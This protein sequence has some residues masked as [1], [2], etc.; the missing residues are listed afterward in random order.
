MKSRGVKTDPID[1]AFGIL[2][3]KEDEERVIGTA[4]KVGSG[5]STSSTKRWNH[6]WHP[7]LHILDTIA[8]LTK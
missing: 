5:S 1:C 2:S 3:R 4:S 6:I 8:V 7:A